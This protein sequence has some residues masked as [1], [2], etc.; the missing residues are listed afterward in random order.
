MAQGGSKISGADVVQSGSANS[1]FRLQP[2]NA[3]GAEDIT[4]ELLR[5]VQFRE[6]EI[7]DREGEIEEIHQSVRDVN[8][9]FKDLAGL[10]EEQ[11]E[12]ID[13]IE[14][15]IDNA[16]SR[17]GGGVEQL[18]T[19]AGYQ[20]AANKKLCYIFWILFF[21]VAVVIII[22]AKP[23]K[24]SPTSRPTLSPTPSPSSP[25]QHTP[26]TFLLKPRNRIYN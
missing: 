14:S 9:V 1:T 18:K 12:E 4:P 17:T 20:S 5:E 2:G 15:R 24:T 26:K 22:V 25:Q 3:R 21:V 6:V 7:E 23:W 16:H 8:E 19:A 11:G 13:M 10:V